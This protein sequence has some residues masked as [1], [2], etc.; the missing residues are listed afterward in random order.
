LGIAL[1]ATLLTLT[2]LAL[3]GLYDSRAEKKRAA[4]AER[5]NS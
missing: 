4:D 1:L 5:R 3:A 2:I